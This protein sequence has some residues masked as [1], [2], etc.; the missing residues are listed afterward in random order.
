M[1]GASPAGRHQSTAEIVNYGR[2]TA[3]EQNGI[4]SSSDD[5]TITNKRGGLISGGQYGYGI[6][7]VENDVTVINSGTIKGG[8]QGAIGLNTG[9][10]TVINSGKIIGDVKLN[11]GNDTYVD[12]GGSV[13]GV[14]N[15]GVGADTYIISHTGLN[16]HED[17]FS[18]I[19]TV[20]ASISWT[21]GDNFE[22]LV[23]TGTHKINGTGTTDADRIIGNRSQ[24][25]ITG[26][27]GDDMLTGG[28]GADRFVFRAG[29]GHDTITDFKDGV[30]RINVS[31]YDNVDGIKD[32]GV[33]K[34]GDD[35]LVTLL[36]GD[37]VLLQHVSSHDISARDFMF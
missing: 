3:G 9:N 2:I 19:D 18:D 16:L 17:D 26:L 13:T 32:I 1:T 25:V 31:H 21:L 24:N 6:T 28:A 20:R 11:N 35:T 4:Y 33:S 23:L 5:L 27:G 12:K 10:D 22:K 30:D 34:S 29:S 15:A 8:V 7:S 36:N 14:I 37:T